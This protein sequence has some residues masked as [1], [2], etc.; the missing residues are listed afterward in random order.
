MRAV[1]AAWGDLGVGSYLK[2]KNDVTWKI[3][4]DLCGEFDI[5]NREGKKAVLKP[6]PATTP[7]TL[8]IPEPS[9]E[10]A[11]L[12]AELG[13]AVMGRRVNGAEVWNCAPFEG[14]TM[15]D[16]IAHLKTFHRIKADEM[17]DVAEI[18][19]LHTAEHADAFHGDGRTGGTPHNHRDTPLGS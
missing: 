16:M 9:P 11:L 4:S 14:G 6:R 12:A 17:T 7:V 10:E 18:V 5:V 13:A 2:D 3:T 19:R 8:L 15:D 1:E